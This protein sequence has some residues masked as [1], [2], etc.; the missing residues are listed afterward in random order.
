MYFFTKYFSKSAMKRKGDKF[1][2]PCR[3]D[4]CLAIVEQLAVGEFDMLFLIRKMQVTI[5]PRGREVQS[6]S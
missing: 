2:L 6:H 4:Y 1:P 5:S 3:S